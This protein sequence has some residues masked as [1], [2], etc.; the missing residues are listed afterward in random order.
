MN[1]LLE[2]IRQKD[3]SAFTHSGKFHADDVFSSALLLYLNPEITITRG[4]KVPDDFDGIVFDIGRGR[5]DHHQKDSRI[6]ENGISYAAFGLLWEDLGCEILGDEL[7]E[8][9]DEAFVQPLDNNDNTGEKNELASLI[10][11]FNPSWDENGGTDEAFFR[12]VS[13]AGMILENKFARY[14]GNERADKRIEEVLET[15]DQTGDSRILVLPEFIPCQKRLSETEV[16]FVIFPS[17]H[18]GYCIQPQ[19]KEYSLNYKCSFPSEWLGLEN[20]ELQKETGLSSATFCHKGGFL[21]SVGDLS[22]A[23]RACQISLDAFTEE[24]TLVN[25]GDDTSADTLLAQLPGLA[26]AKIIHK[27]LPEFPELTLDGIYGEV[28][29]EKPEW[30]TYVKDQVKELLKTKPEAVY[31]NGN[32]FSLYPIVHQLRKK[33]IPVLTSSMKDGKKIIIRIPSGS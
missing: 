7:A 10:G 5:Y 6:R 8:K 20:E 28:T 18:G 33:H 17:N 12:A 29:M 4:N 15:R 9:F 14:L 22:D 13:V 24:I 11:S 21:M 3:A 19:K 26:H 23:I 16:A 25:L 32:L 1:Q 30:K 31:V 2:M 27:S